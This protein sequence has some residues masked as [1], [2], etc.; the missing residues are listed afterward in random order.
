MLAFNLIPAFP[1][2]GGR[3]LRS[4]LWS[5]T[6]NLKRATYWASQAGHAFAWLLIGWGL[7]QFFSEN[8]LGGIWTCL[9]GLFLNKAAQSGYQQVLVRDVLKGEQVHRFMTKDPIVVPASLTLRRWVEDYVYQYHRKT[10][11]V[12]SDGR[13]EGCVET[14]ALSKIPRAD[15]DKHTVG[16]LMRRDLPALTIS[17]DA[18]ALDAMAKMQRSDVGCLLVTAGDR[19]EGIIS[20]GDVLHFLHLKLDLE[21]PEGNSAGRLS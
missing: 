20:L 19:L 12:V 3:V 6:G 21:G 7:L 11:P 13:L 10:F 15:W 17:P 18:D 2:D 16:D 14:T 4:V 8:W 1:L 9:I 5:A